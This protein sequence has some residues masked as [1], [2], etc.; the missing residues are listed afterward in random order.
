[1]ARGSAKQARDRA[2]QAILPLRGKILNVASASRDK[3]A[4]NQ[5]L[6][7]LTLALGCGVGKQYKDSELRYDRV[8]VMTDADVDGAHIASLL[9]TF[10][11]RQMPELI[12]NGHLYLA[13]PP[14]YRLSQGG[15]TGIARDDAHLGEL[16]ATVF[17]GRGKLEVSQFKGLG[18]MMPAQLKE[19]TMTPSKR[20]LLRVEIAGRSGDLNGLD[21][22]ADEAVRGRHR[23]AAHGQQARGAL[24]LH[25]GA[26]G[27]RRARGAGYLARTQRTAASAAMRSRDRLHNSLCSRIALRSQ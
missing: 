2:T 1:M 21:L 26:R 24:P 9:I 5:L 6:A 23:R 25:T 4:Q 16:K 14:L 15:K 3:L 27:L 19:T 22:E 8:I 17:N 20:T 13:V 10:F 11:Y 18:E 12:R 7:D